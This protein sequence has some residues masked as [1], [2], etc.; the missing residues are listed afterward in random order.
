M[1]RPWQRTGTNQRGNDWRAYDDGGY[2]YRNRDSDGGER[3]RYI[4]PGDGRR[5]LED[6]P[7]RQG[8]NQRGNDWCRYPSGA[9][10]YEN[11][12]PDGGIANRYYRPHDGHEY[13]KAPNG[14]GWHKSPGGERVVNEQRGSAAS[15]V[16]HYSSGMSSGGSSSGGASVVHGRSGRHDSQPYRSQHAREESI[17]S[18]SS[19]RA[20]A[21]HGRSGL[22]M[23][24][25]PANYGG[26]PSSSSEDET[27]VHCY[28][29]LHISQPANY[30]S[31]S[32]SEDEGE[33]GYSGLCY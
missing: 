28:S 13:L 27:V 26:Y 15:T 29:G 14:A 10:E 23:S 4:S 31:S 22:H 17:S 8:T 3:N 16:P 33:V 32:S 30:E 6:P 19:S 21:G 1:Q 5:Y 11:K 25:Q 2:E 9:Y 18:S 7:I 12:S 20:S 24:Q